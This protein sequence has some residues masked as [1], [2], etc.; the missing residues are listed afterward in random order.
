M[1][2]RASSAADTRPDPLRDIP[3]YWRTFREFIGARMYLVFALMLLEALLEGVGIVML[4]PLLQ[5]LDA[6]GAVPGRFA[7]WLSD[8][9][10]SQGLTGPVPVLTT[11]AAVFL[12]IGRAHV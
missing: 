6:G 2:T 7:S 12:E 4:L 9:L 11:I 10:A 8:A 3:S 5:T 1:S